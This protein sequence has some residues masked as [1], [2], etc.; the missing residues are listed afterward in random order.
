MIL[1]IGP[2]GSG[3]TF[4]NW[5]IIF[6][7]G[8]ITYT[9]LNNVSIPVDI[10]PLTGP[11]AHGFARDHIYASSNLSRLKLG[12]EKSVIYITVTHQDDLNHIAQHN[13]KKIVF[14]CQEKSKELFARMVKCVP[15][16]SVFKLVNEL[17][18]KFGKDQ[19]KT[20]LLECSDLFTHYYSIPEPSEEYFVITY[21]DIFNNL[22][23]KISEMFLFLDIPIDQGRFAAWLKIYNQYQER[24]KC[25]LEEFKPA[26][27]QIS[28]F[29]KLQIIK[30]VI[31]WR[32]HSYQQK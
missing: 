5:T 15:N 20:V 6:L 21:S 16:T 19:T 24:N 12:S 22:D 32:T 9:T 1:T 2:G 3:L 8:D 30:E 25:M 4:L 17:S 26:P 14:N 27:T 10:N 18:N 29:T 31:K 28:N 13:C 7:R 23:Q 11:I